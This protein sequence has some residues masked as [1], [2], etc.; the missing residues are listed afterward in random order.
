MLDYWQSP[1]IAHDYASAG[2][3]FQALFVHPA[4]LAACLPFPSHLAVS[5]PSVIMT[6]EPASGRTVR[7]A[8]GASGRT[9]ERAGGWKVTFV[10]GAASSLMPPLQ[11]H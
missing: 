7:R 6:S 11:Q 3:L 4:F 5:Q 10:T 8:V 2:G 9:D 1:P